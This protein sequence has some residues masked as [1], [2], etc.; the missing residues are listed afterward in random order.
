MHIRFLR[1]VTLLS[2]LLLSTPVFAQSVGDRVYTADQS[3][4][5]VSV[6]DPVTLKL[7]GV[8]S[9][10]AQVPAALGPLYKGELLVH[11]L[12]FSPDG[13]TLAAVSIGS[14]STPAVRRWV[15]GRSATRPWPSTRPPSPPMSAMARRLG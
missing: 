2:V 10:G 7:L 14:R 8:I 4:N 15:R 5:T 11:G 3:S 13:K 12:G 1:S 6:I 9:L